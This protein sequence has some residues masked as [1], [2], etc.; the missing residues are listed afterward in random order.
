MGNRYAKVD[1]CLENGVL[2]T[3]SKELYGH[4]HEA[5]Q[6]QCRIIDRCRNMGVDFRAAPQTLDN[7]QAPILDWLRGRCACRAGKTIYRM[8]QKDAPGKRL[9]RLR[10][11]SL[12]SLQG[13]A[14]RYQTVTGRSF[15][16][17]FIFSSLSWRTWV[18][19]S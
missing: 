2:R 15:S 10:K 9:R 3:N 11:Y 7:L 5:R 18:N 16:N 8:G 14:P 4:N 6:S 1:K 12:M 13:A 19:K 17:W